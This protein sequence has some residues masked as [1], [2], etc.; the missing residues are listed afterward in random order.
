MKH[1]FF[2]IN[3]YKPEGKKKK[4]WKKPTEEA[5]RGLLIIF[6]FLLLLGV[7]SYLIF[8]LYI[9]QQRTLE[10]ARSEAGR[11]EN[12]LQAEKRLS[13]SLSG[14][15]EIYLQIKGEAVSWPEKLYALS[16]I[17][18]NNIWFSKIEFPGRSGNIEGGQPLKISAW[19]FSGLME[20][21]LDQIGD[22]IIGLNQAEE[23]KEDFNPLSLE[24][25]KKSDQEWGMV[26]FQMTGKT[27]NLTR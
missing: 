2:N 4:E 11:L 12:K 27:K 24:Y 14:K 3:I 21:N 22:L 7:C 13:Q 16:E 8:G 10:E 25:T 18:P 9:P 19:T 6:S 1:S 17:L 26:Q 20:Q 15:R 5:Y 23:F